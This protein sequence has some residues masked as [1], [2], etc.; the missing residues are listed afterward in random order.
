MID[1]NTDMFSVDRTE[2]CV[3]PVL[4]RSLGYAKETCRFLCGQERAFANAVGLHD[5]TLS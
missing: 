1:D 3:A 2:T 4:E 5:E